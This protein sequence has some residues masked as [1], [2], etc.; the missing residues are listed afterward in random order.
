[1]PHF[2]Q[3]RDRLQPAEA[4]FDALPLTLRE[5]RKRNRGPCHTGQA[6]VEPQVE[7]SAVGQPARSVSGRRPRAGCE[8]LKEGPPC[9]PLRAATRCAN[10]GVLSQGAEAGGQEKY[11]PE[12]GNGKAN[13]PE[14]R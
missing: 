14:Q 10:R 13:L 6:A 3:Q 2:P 1:M 9:L 8:R 5:E 7:A 12:R 11:A 4:F